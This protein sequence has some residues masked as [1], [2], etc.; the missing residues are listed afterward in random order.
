MARIENAIK[1]KPLKSSCLYSTKPL[2][3]CAMQEIL[4]SRT[5]FAEADNPAWF[6]NLIFVYILFDLDKKHFVIMSKWKRFPTQQQSPHVIYI[7]GTVINKADAGNEV[8]KTTIALD[9]VLRIITIFC[10]D[11]IASAIPKR[12]LYAMLKR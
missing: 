8:W 9:T 10:L 11:H 4:K 5:A 12:T 1:K 6:T 7:K 2:A 3:G